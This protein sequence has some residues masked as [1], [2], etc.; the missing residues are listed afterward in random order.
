MVSAAH[1]AVGT[2]SEERTVERV[3]CERILILSWAS[4]IPVK[5]D[6]TDLYDIMAFFVGGPDGKNGHD[7][8]GKKIAMQGQEWAKYHWREV[9]M[10]GQ[11]SSFRSC[12]KT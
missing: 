5:V 7:Q 1:N 6:Y 2:V 4:Y 11:F 8:L 12:T 10:Q 9:D 3:G